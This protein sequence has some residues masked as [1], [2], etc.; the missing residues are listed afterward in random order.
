MRPQ[1]AASKSKP[2]NVNSTRVT[3]LAFLK[4]P[5]FDGN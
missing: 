1:D 2:A 3:D 5:L 4:S